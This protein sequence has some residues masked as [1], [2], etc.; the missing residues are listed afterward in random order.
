MR[1]AAAAKRRSAKKETNVHDLLVVIATVKP[2]DQQTIEVVEYP[3][4]VMGIAEWHGPEF[5]PTT[6]LAMANFRGRTL[7]EFYSEFSHLSG[8]EQAGSRL[9]RFGIPENPQRPEP[10]RAERR[11]RRGRNDRRT[12]LFLEDAVDRRLAAAAAS[13]GAGFGADHVEGTGPFADAGADGAVGYGSAVADDHSP[14]NVASL[15]TTFNITCNKARFWP[16]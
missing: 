10:R 6:P 4:G 16:K 7:A 11:V 14:P 1:P 9:R 15:K 12:Q 13:A 3:E 2:S 5:D 8:N